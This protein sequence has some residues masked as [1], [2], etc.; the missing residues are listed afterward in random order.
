M[1]DDAYAGL[2]EQRNRNLVE[3][4]HGLPDAPRAPLLRRA[5]QHRPERDENSCAARNIVNSLYRRHGEQIT[6]FRWCGQS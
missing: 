6:S 3:P 4:V 5:V 2:A 1:A